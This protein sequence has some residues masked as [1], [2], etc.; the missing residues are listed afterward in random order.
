MGCFGE[1]SSNRNGKKTSLSL[2]GDTLGQ[3]LK[4]ESCPIKGV[5]CALQLV[6]LNSA[7]RQHAPT[8]FMDAMACLQVHTHIASTI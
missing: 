8:C 3:F 7:N 4:E 1:A 6:N 2:L 5:S